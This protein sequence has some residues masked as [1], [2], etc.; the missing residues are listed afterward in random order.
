M[1][2]KELHKHIKK[3]AFPLK[4][5]KELELALKARLTKKELK[6]LRAMA[7]GCVE[8]LQQKLALDEESLKVLEL[9]LIKKLN[10]EKTKQT[11]YDLNKNE[12]K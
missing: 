4:K 6:L 7:D 10:Y 1:L 11:L 3:L 8:A 12:A 2:E 5:G 9:K